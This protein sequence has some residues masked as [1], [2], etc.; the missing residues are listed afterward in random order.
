VP[1]PCRVRAVS[2]PCPCRGRIRFV[3]LLVSFSFNPLESKRKEKGYTPEN[4]ISAASFFFQTNKLTNEHPFPFSWRVRAV[5]V[6]VS[7][8]CPCLCPCRVRVRGRIRFVSLLVSFSFNPL[9][10]KRR[11]KGYTP[12]KEI[13]AASFFFQTNKLTNEHPFPSSWR[14]V[15]VPCPC[16]VRGG[17][18]ACPWRVRGVSV[19]G[20][21]RVRAALFW[22]VCLFFPPQTLW[23]HQE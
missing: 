1:C 23:N 20:P 11:E 15:S 18:V 9:E 10:S 8:P 4:E 22:F 19:A 12:E 17:S 3:S 14:A 5:S 13:S 6:F 16:R 2:V 7:M 21:W